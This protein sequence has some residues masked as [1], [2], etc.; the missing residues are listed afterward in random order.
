MSHNPL[1]GSV[2]GSELFWALHH[3]Q[4]SAE[5]LTEISPVLEARSEGTHE[6]KYGSPTLLESE[7][8]RQIDFPGLTRAEPC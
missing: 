5:C 7:R 3:S 2:C 8:G 6:I 4:N 1:R